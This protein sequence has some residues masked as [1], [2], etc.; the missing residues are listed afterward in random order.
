MEKKT[1]LLTGATG[2]L[3]SNLLKKLVKDRSFKI[4]VLKRS[5]SNTFR[6]DDC[7]SKVKTFDIDRVNL[8][9]VFKNNRIDTVI[10]CA[11]DYGRKNTDVLQIIE[12]NL[13]LPVRLLELAKKHTARCF[14]NTDTI[15]DKRINAYSLSKKQFKEWLFQSGNSMVC[16]NIALEHFYGPGDDKTKFASFI[17]H[18]MLNKVESINLTKGGQKRDFIFIDDVTE[19]FMK[20]IRHSGILSKSF[21]EFQIG[22]NKAVTIKEFVLLIKKLTNNKKTV[23]NFGA[24]PYRDNEVMECQTD[25]RAIKKLGWSARYALQEGLKRTIKRERLVMKKI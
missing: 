24:L 6:I 12:A 18:S 17:I 16:V 11:T 1:I 3:G 19:A 8:E 21:C 5:F 15:L 7:L 2:Y 13:L 10:H 9:T 23:L 20:I 4:V 14:I 22:S 25:T